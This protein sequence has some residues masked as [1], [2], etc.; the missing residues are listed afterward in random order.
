MGLRPHGLI[1][2]DVVYAEPHRA[3]ER[4][5]RVAATATVADVLRLA[6][7]DPAF[8]GINVMGAA[9]G[10]FGLRANSDQALND[11]DRLEIYRPLAADPKIARRARARQERRQP[12]R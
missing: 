1:G 4:T 12:K 8:G 9:V 2:I 7:A 6:A 10:I 5:Y 11:E 3:V